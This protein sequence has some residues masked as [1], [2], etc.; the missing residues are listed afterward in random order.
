[1]EG[2][3]EPPLKRAERALSQ[4]DHGLALRLAGEVIARRPDQA[5][6]YLIRGQA[7]YAAGHAM[8][9][10]ADLLGGLAPGAPPA[11]TRMIEGQLLRRLAAALNNGWGN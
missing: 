10:M 6:A 4:G 5:K 1:M 3:G 9:G 8:L 7:H 11:V 2:A